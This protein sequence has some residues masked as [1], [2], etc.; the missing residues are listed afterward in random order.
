MWQLEIGVSKVN[1]YASRDSGDTVEIIERPSGGLSVVIADA[2][3]TGAA[4]KTLSNLVTSKAIALIKEGARDTAV[5]QAVNDHL[6]HY[7]GGRVSCTLT[8]ISVDLNRQACLVTRN[9]SSPVFL[10]RAGRL[11]I[12]DVSS[13]PLGYR[14]DSHPVEVSVGLQPDTMVVAATDGVLRAGERSGAVFEIQEYI[15]INASGERTPEELADQLLAK[16]I[17]HDSQR[18][19]DDMTVVVAGIVRQAETSERRTMSVA[20]PIL[21]SNVWREEVRYAKAPG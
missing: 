18:P 9:S 21:R 2:Q 5:H 19:A 16:A 12:S 20:I 1:K 15:E 4:A 14:A 10:Y 17:E 6:Y 3:G 13:M 11:E 8:T 7:R